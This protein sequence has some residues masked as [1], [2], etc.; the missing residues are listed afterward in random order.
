MEIIRD[1]YKS[2]R[3]GAS[4]ILNIHCREC[5]TIVIEYQKDGTGNLYRLYMDRIMAP[6]VYVGWQ[7]KD[8]NGIEPLRCLQCKT[9]IAMPYIHKKENRNAFRIIQEAMVKRI[10]K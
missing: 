4:K 8:I 6:D 9:I 3:S 1:K 5:D 2:A 10:K 7:N